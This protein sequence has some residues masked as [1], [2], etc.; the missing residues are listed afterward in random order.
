MGP[1]V[2]HAVTRFNKGDNILQQVASEVFD[3]PRGQIGC[4]ATTDVLE[5]GMAIRHY[6]DHGLHSTLRQQI[7]QDQVGT[8]KNRPGSIVVSGS[9]KQVKHWISSRSVFVVRWRGV[10]MEATA[11]TA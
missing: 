11:H 9:V 2:L 10:H 6:D 3:I 4:G 7:V 8:T 1:I 5:E